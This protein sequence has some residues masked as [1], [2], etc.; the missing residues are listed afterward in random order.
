MAAAAQPMASNSLADTV[1]QFNG[2]YYK[3][4]HRDTNS[5]LWVT[6][7]PNIPFYAQPGAMVS[8]SPEVTLKGKFKFSFKK[9]FTGGEM[10][11]STYTGPGEILFA[12][13]IWGDIVPIE[14]DGRAQWNVGKGGYLA[15]SH[16]V[17][18]ET[19]SQG[20]GKAM[21]SG[22]GL[23]VHRISGVGVIFVTSLG[24]IVQR[25]LRQD[26]QWIVDNGHLVA[27]NCPYTIERAG[28]GIMS[29]MHAGEG[30]VCRFTGP[31]TVYIQTR[32]PEALSEWIASHTSTSSS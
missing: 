14:L 24:A 13:P 1:G 23:F 25:H 10:A 20:L 6:L 11:Q 22:E 5:V 2:G 19:K 9:M 8:M 17:V 16:G 28:G 7:Q 30:L 32:N 27:W 26:E 18:K 4:D 31:G 15:M 12:P 3:I 29:G 21:F